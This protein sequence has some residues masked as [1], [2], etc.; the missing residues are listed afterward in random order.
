[1][2]AEI[3]VIPVFQ[4]AAARLHA[5]LALREQYYRECDALERAMREPPPRTRP[6]ALPSR[7]AGERQ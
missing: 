1:M 7:R 6:I 2:T 4:D 5:D 3:I